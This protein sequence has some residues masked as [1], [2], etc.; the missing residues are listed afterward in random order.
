MGRF[1]A[2]SI[3]THRLEPSVFSV[4]TNWWRP[5]SN[6]VT[7]VPVPCCCMLGERSSR[8]MVVSVRPPAALPN[9][10]LAIGRLT[11]N[12]SPAIANT[13]KVRISHWRSRAYPRDIRWAVSK[14]IIAPQRID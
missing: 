2:L 12:R 3:N 6:L 9:Q 10:P 11:A 13:R 7:T 8:I 1:D 4:C 5:A 14:N